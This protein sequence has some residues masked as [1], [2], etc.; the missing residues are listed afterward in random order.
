MDEVKR[1]VLHDDGFRRN[2][3]SYLLSL[4]L[5]PTRP[6]QV[7]I[8]PYRKNRSLAQN[9]L[10]WDWV[11]TIAE[12]T[13]NT[14]RQMHRILKAEFLLPILARDYKQIGVVER[15]IGGDPEGED[16]LIDL[17]TTT[18]LNTKQFTE[19]LREIEEWAGDQAIR[20]RTPDDDDSYREAMGIR[21]ARR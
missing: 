1:F 10:Y 7:E 9:S 11:T 8:K 12:D 14:K 6:L 15:A 2:A 13:G 21:R 20:L 4:E 3:L 16:A 19:Y 18:D 17:L 5:D